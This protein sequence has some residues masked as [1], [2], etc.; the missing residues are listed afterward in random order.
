MERARRKKINNNSNPEI[1]GARRNI[2][3]TAKIYGGIS[4]EVN[5]N[6][7]RIDW[8]EGW[9]INGLRRKEIPNIS[10]DGVR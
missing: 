2:T 10:D 7:G 1:N 5:V 6:R 9:T 8:C 4:I 3:D